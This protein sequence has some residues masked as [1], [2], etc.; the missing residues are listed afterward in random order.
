MTCNVLSGTLT[1]YT[2]T[3]FYEINRTPEML[4]RQA[5]SPRHQD[6]AKAKAAKAK[7][8]VSSATKGSHKTKR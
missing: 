3:T 4:I 1:L 7:A 5:V 6:M 8:K 2:T